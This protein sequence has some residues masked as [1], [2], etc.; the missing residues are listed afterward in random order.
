MYH[1]GIALNFV[2][3]TLNLVKKKFFLKNLILKGAIEPS[4]PERAAE[5]REARCSGE[6]S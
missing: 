4:E 6:F 5:A 1:I 2:G 3:L